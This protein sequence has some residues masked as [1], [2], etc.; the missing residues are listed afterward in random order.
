MAIDDY[1]LVHAHGRL[2]SGQDFEGNLCGL[3]GQKTD[4]SLSLD[5][6]G[7]LYYSMNV[8]AALEFT[9]GGYFSSANTTAFVP[10]TVGLEMSQVLDP[11]R[12]YSDYGNTLISSFESYFIPDCLSECDFNVTSDSNGTARQYVWEGPS[13]PTMVENWLAYKQAAELDS[14]LM[15]PFTFAALPLSVCPYA[16]KYCVPLQYA[17]FASLLERYCIPKIVD[18]SSGSSYV[19]ESWSDVLSVGFGDMMGDVHKTWPLILGMAVAALV[20]A[21]IFLFILR[22][23][24]G[25]FIWLTIFLCF[26]LMILGAVSTLLWS[27]KCVGESLFLAAQTIQSTDAGLTLLEGQRVCSNGYSIPDSNGRFV[28]RVISYVLFGLSVLYLI[29]VLLLC[30]KIRIGIAMNKVAAQFVRH[31][32]SALLVPLFQV[33]ALIAWWALWLTSIVYTLTT[34]PENY[35]DM[36]KTWGAD[37]YSAAVSACSGE[38]GV[39]MKTSSSIMYACK[40]P[41]YYLSWEFYYSIASLIWVNVFLVSSG[42]MIIAGAVGVWYF[43]PSHSKKSLGALPVRTGF[44]NTFIYHLGTLAFGSLILGA[45]RLVRVAFFWQ[46]WINKKTIP[47]NPLLKCFVG[48]INAILAF[49]DKII[50]FL[51]KNAFIQTALMGTNFCTSCAAAVSL[52]VR[53]LALIGALGVIGSAVHFLGMIFITTATGFA[54]WALLAQFYDGQISS[55]IIPTLACLIM[56][57]FIGSVVISVFSLSVDSILQCYLADEELHKSEGGAKYTP[58][59]LQSFLSS[60]HHVVN[61]LPVGAPV[62][63]VAA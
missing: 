38:N 2:F 52:I 34:I 27:Q 36:S 25:V 31:N 18:F 32:T 4:G 22:L 17:E 60:E 21:S 37:E 45:V 3:S 16:E 35:R 63:V 57:Y 19:P 59:E 61:N 41:K 40:E 9:V 51:N 43:T 39:Y 8:T 56:G 23:C 1:M 53:N 11:S 58:S 54:G 12:F 24:V 26:L 10:E 5:S 55:P 6:F 44:R 42:Q 33:L 20:I 47:S 62:N 50:T 29:A 30:K 15:E 49:I 14:S 48:C 7:L 28:V 46:S 13:D